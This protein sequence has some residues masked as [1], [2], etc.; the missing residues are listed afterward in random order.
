[1]KNPLTAVRG[2]IEVVGGR[3][4]SDSKEAPVVK[5]IL[6]RLD[7]LNDLLKDLLLFARPPQPKLGLVD[8]RSL[9]VTV[10][11]LLA[12]DPA[13]AGVRMEVAGDSSHVVADANLLQ[14]VLQNLFINAAQAMPAGG[15]IRASVDSSED[16]AVVTVRDTGPGLSAEAREKLFRPFFTSKARG[17]GLGL[18]T[19]KRLVEA[20]GGT[21]RVESPSTG[22][23]LV[24]LRI[25]SGARDRVGPR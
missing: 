5:Q 13:F 2:A 12:Q 9:L 23:V 10:G 6:A 22:G 24:T 16:A 4:P 25:P 15:D 11:E 20:H 3:L 14:I 1:V 21:I 17:T 18:S 19:A 8:L 7:A